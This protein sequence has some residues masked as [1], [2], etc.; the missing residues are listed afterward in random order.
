ML[1]YNSFSA[2]KHVGSSVTLF[3]ICYYYSK[4]AI[5]FS[6][7]NYKSIEYETSRGKSTCSIYRQ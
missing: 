5:L 2:D 1:G 7:P 3:V 6:G 4:F